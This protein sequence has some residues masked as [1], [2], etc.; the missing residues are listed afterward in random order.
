MV[1]SFKSHSPA[2]IRDILT[3]GSRNIWSL[4]VVHICSSARLLILC[5][6]KFLKLAFMINKT[7][8]NNILGSTLALIDIILAFDV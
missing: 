7:I 6:W 3:A 4:R 8:L 5:K 2:A 1:G